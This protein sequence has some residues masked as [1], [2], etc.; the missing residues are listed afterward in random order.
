MNVNKMMKDLQRLQEELQDRLGE[1]RVEGTS[2]G[3]LVRAVV[4]GHRTLHA[5]TLKKEAVDPDDLE[6]LQDLVLAAVNDAVRM[7]D[8]RGKE[9]TAQ[10]LGPL[11]GGLNIPGLM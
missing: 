5:I 6:M 9:L 11:A 10:M 4:D 2:G 7:A 8:A 1:M 3:G